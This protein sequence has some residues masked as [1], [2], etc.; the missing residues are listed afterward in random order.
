MKEGIVI[1]LQK[2]NHET[3]SVDRN[4][5]LKGSNLSYDMKDK[6]YLAIKLS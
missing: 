6:G 1:S 5:L 2:M 3:Y 4:S